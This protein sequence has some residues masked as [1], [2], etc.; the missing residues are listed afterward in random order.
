MLVAEGR[1]ETER[2]SRYLVQLCRHVHLV[3][4]HNPRMQAHV[5]WSHDRG[6]ISFGWGRCTLRAHPRVLTL[7]AEAPDEERLHQLQQ[8]VA[9][10]LQQ[11]GRRDRLTVTWTLATPAGRPATE[12]DTQRG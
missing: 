7:R 8:R 12:E 6:E 9:D 10:R 1:A 2:A 3:A 11:I 4:Q 5:H